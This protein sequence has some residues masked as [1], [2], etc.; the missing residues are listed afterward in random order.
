MSPYIAE[1]VGTM[2]LILLGDGVVANV[3]LARSK[4]QNSGWIVITVGWGVAVTIAVYAVG[5]ISGAHLNP[6]VT[7]GL[8]A[9]GSFPWAERGRLH[10]RADGWSVSWRRPRVARVPAA[11]AP[12]GRPRGKAGRLF[13]QPGRSQR[14]REL[15]DRS[16]RHRHAAVRH[17]RHRRERRRVGAGRRRGPV[18]GV[19]PRA[20]TAAGRHSGARDRPVAWRSDRLRDKPRARSRATARARRSSPFPARDHQIGRTRGFRSSRRSPAASRA[21]RCIPSSDSR[22]HMARYVGALDQGTTSTR[23]MVFDVAGAEVARRQIEHTQIMPKPGWVEH[24]PVEIAARTNEVIT[25]ALAC[26]KSRRNR[27]RRH[28]RDQSARNHGGVESEDRASLVQRHRVAGHADRS[29]CQRPRTEATAALRTHGASASDIFFRYQA[30]M[31]SRKRRR[32]T[33]RRRTRRRRVRQY[34]HLGDMEPHRRHRRWCARNRRHQREPHTSHGSSDARLGRRTACLVRDSAPHAPG[35]SIVVRSAW[36]R[37]DAPQRAG[38]SRGSGVRRSR[39]STSG[40][41]WSGVLFGRRGEE[42]VRHRQLHA[43][44][45]RKNSDAFYDRPSHDCVLQTGR[46]STGLRARRICRRHRFGGAVASRSARDHRNRLGSGSVG[47]HGAR[48]WRRLFCAGI[49]GTVRALLARRTRAE[50]SSACRAST[51]RGTWLARH[52]RPSVSRHARCST[53]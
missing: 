5:R 49:L 11:L 40:D 47:E 23:F 7:I 50:R 44:Q 21:R 27:P 53:P 43:A 45:H 16:D 31:D 38:G 52:S 1:A 18:P 14:C 2:I 22:R 39:R 48:Q 32:R 19:Q 42:H 30:A 4:G 37:Y 46:D 34:R 3:L 28:R 17:P 35:D 26:R 20:A 8:A 29:D 6:A 15:H 41:G 9:I 36:L 33:G 10:C 13:Q 12:D 24:D 25:G 51:T